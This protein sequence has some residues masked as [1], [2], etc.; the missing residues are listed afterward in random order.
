MMRRYVLFSVLA[1]AATAVY[2]AVRYPGL[3]ESIAIHWGPGGR[4]DSFAGR[5]AGAS[6][7][8][9]T[10]VLMLGLLWGLA[11][12]PANRRKV[13]NFADVYGQT[14]FGTVAFLGIMQAL[15]L[16]AA[17]G[18]DVVMQGTMVAMWLFF[19]F[20][21]NLMGKVTPNGLMGIRT[22]RTL[23]D[24]EVWR[25]THRWSARFMVT[26]ALVGLVF[27]L[28]GANIW[29]QLGLIMV[30]AFGPV[31]YASTVRPGQVP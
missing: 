18:R 15:V 28:L 13:A 16:E 26:V 25:L 31:V 5:L 10:Q 23:A 19:A 21:G 29:F 20:L 12:L 27:A 24:P 9:L 1:I 14:V 11:A 4:P 3:P 8:P 22:P 2:T 7:L 17:L 30:W 6:L